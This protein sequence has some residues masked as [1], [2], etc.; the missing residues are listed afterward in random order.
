VLREVAEEAFSS[1]NPP[2]LLDGRRGRRSPTK[3]A[4]ID[5]LEYSPLSAPDALE[6]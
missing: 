5:E 2:C 6:T 4:A 1:L 3:I